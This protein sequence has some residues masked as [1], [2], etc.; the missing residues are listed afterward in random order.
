MKKKWL[1]IGLFVALALIQIAVPVS[2]IVRREHALRYGR[3]FKFRTRPVDPYDAFR[4]RYIALGFEQDE[5]SVPPNSSLKR[6]QKVYA[7]LA[8]DKE[9]FTAADRITLTPPENV[10][11]IKVKVQWLRRGKAG[12]DLP[13]GRYYMDEGAAPAAEHAYQ[14]YMQQEARDAYVTVRVR[15]GLAV[16]EELYVA[17]KP[18]VEFTQSISELAKQLK[19]NPPAEK[20]LGV[21]VYPGAKFDPE[22]SASMSF[23]SDTMYYVYSFKEAPT[24]VVSFYEEKTGKKTAGAEPDSRWP[25]RRYILPIEGA[26]PDPDEAVIIWWNTLLI[27]KQNRRN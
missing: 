20:D 17:G 26:M 3:Q 10:D 15:G 6:G 4:G 5:V 1:L 7:L 8:T 27:K 25:A 21:P 12:L 2:T 11:Y 18:I 13:F 23:G 24:E 16:L 14:T 9:G 19:N 22:A